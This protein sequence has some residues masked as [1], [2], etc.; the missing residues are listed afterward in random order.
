MNGK[1]HKINEAY[2]HE[3]TGKVVFTVNTYKSIP[4]LG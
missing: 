1:I 2:V 4:S 3:P